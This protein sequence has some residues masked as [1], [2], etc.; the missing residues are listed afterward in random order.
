MS[1]KL[2]ELQT[3]FVL[4][5]S[6]LQFLVMPRNAGGRS[7]LTDPYPENHL[8][9]AELIVVVMSSIRVVMS[10]TLMVSYSSILA[11]VNLMTALSNVILT[12]I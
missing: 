9:L 1:G 2:R 8:W 12:M 7:Y 11:S 6:I 10:R 5:L 4:G 3:F